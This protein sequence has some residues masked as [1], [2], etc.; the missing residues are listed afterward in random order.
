[1]RNGPYMTLRADLHL[2]ITRLLFE[3]SLLRDDRL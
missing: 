1:M 3:G 2:E